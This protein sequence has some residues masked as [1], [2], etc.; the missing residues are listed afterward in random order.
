MN[1]S[2]HAEFLAANI[3][4][5]GYPFVIEKIYEGER[6]EHALAIEQRRLNPHGAESAEKMNLAQSKF[7]RVK[8]ITRLR[9][10]QLQAAWSA[11]K[12]EWNVADH[13]AKSAKPP[14]ASPPKPSPT[15]VVAKFLADSP[16]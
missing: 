7:E 2:P 14:E 15:E 5:L 9:L 1:L 6:D 12:T 4:N 8:S 13:A 11:A 16:E 10:D 3:G